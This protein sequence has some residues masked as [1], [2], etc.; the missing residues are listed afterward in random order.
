MKVYNLKIFDDDR[1]RLSPLEF[2][3]LPFIPKR[4]FF[5][6]QVP[7]G[8]TRG[9]H[10]HYST[11]QFIICLSGV[12]T[13]VLNNGW[14]SEEQVINPNQAVFIDKMIW[15]YQVF[16]TGN[17]SLAV[18]CSTEY[19]KADYILD[20]KYFTQLVRDSHTSGEIVKPANETIPVPG[21]TPSNLIL[22]EPLP[23]YIP[24]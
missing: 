21:I 23:R 13:V 5:V 14:W 16:N 11:Q 20:F 24:I 15:D 17:D 3:E 22:N 1:G 6:T 2:K 19:N 4:I 10:A 18:L 9:R 7:I 8:T 12:V